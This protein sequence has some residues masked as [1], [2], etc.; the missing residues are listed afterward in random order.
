MDMP[1]MPGISSVLVVL[2]IALG[3]N[4]LISVLLLNYFYSRSPQPD[5]AYLRYCMVYYLC[6]IGGYI[7]YLSRTFYSPGLSVFLTNVFAMMAACAVLFA[8]QSRF[9]NKAHPWRS[10]WLLYPFLVAAIASFF[11]YRYPDKLI[12]RS[13]NL[14]IHSAFVY[15]TALFVTTGVAPRKKGFNT[16]L[17]SFGVLGLILL[18]F[19]IPVVGAGGLEPMLRHSVILCI[20]I[21]ATQIIL[22]TFLVGLLHHRSDSGRDNRPGDS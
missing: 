1:D 17:L 4:N 9:Q 15:L 20:Q 3:L 14:Y 19:I 8:F 12:L 22:A 10:W 6:A 16:T 13:V 21:V 7:A 11:L 2:A 18:S 5:R